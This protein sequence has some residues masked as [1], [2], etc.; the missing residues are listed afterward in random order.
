MSLVLIGGGGHAR[1]VADVALSAGFDVSGVLVP[2]GGL[3]AP[4]LTRLGDDAWL[5]TAPAGTALHVAFG[6]KPGATDRQALFEKLERKG[7]DFPAIIAASAIFRSSEPVGRGSVVMHAATVNVGARI[8]RNSIVN[9]GAIVEHE[10]ELLDHCHVA[11]G[12]RLGGGVRVGTGS[13][14]GLGAVV[15]PGVAIATRVTIG[16]GAVVTRTI[17][18]PFGTWSGVPARRHA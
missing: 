17:D 3:V 2:E 7:F 9:T 4:G 10:C 8:G 5:D 1:A 12:A 15:L 14:V 16:A 18:E 13:M 6:P 11:P